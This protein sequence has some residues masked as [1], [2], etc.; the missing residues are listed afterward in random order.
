[1]LLSLI[2]IGVGVA[3]AAGSTALVLAGRREVR[4]TPLQAIDPA[5]DGAARLKAHQYLRIAQSAVRTMESL[6]V[7]DMVA[8]VIPDAKRRQM[9]DLVDRF[10][11]L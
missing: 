8:V 7:D 11:E 9:Q 5:D 6:L 2:L 10:Y 3:L 1:M 4:R